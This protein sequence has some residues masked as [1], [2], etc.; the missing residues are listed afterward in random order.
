MSLF[1]SQLRNLKNKKFWEQ[2]PL[3]VICLLIQSVLIWIILLIFLYWVGFSIYVYNLLPGVVYTTN[4]NYKI[5]PLEASRIKIY[6]QVNMFWQEH[7]IFTIV[8][9]FILFHKRRYPSFYVVINMM[10]VQNIWSLLITILTLITTKL[11]H[12]SH[13]WNFSYLK[14]MF[15]W[16]ELLSIK[17]AHR[18]WSLSNG[19]SL[20]CI[21]YIR[22]GI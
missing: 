16:L 20:R 3:F 21:C 14:K 5:P 19:N 17:F 7:W 2:L 13:S 18:T 22:I 4:S 11:S 6:K 15:T 1:Q 9:P 10:L 12:F 8:L